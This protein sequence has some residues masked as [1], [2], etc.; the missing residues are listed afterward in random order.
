VFGLRPISAGLCRLR[1]KIFL[2][3]S[4]DTWFAAHLHPTLCRIGERKQGPR[5]IHGT[6]HYFLSIC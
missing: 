5:A 2:P 4:L 6:I 1:K 3:L